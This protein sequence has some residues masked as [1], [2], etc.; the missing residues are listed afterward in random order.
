MNTPTPAGY[1]T[2]NGRFANLMGL[3]L[4]APGTTLAATANSNS[5]ELGDRGTARLTLNVTA[6]GAGTPSMAVTIQT[7]PD[8][9][10]WTTI[11]ATPG[12]A[13]FT[14]ATGVTSQRLIFAGLDRFVRAVATISGGTPSLTFSLS[15]EAV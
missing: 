14:A 8:N 2:G 1:T 15:G 5:V 9:A 4:F 7:S 11:P 10:T 12:A 6:V 13:S 3:I